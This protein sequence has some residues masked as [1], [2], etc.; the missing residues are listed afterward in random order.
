MQLS[1]V[2]VATL[3]ALLLHLSATSALEL[4]END[5]LVFPTGRLAS[6]WQMGGSAVQTENF[7][8]LTPAIQSRVGR[9]W[10]RQSLESDQ[11][12]FEL[13][14]RVNGAKSGADGFALWYTTQPLSEGP[15]FGSSPTWEGMVLFFDT[16]DNDWKRDNPFAGIMIN[17]GTKEINFSDDGRAHSP[18]GCMMRFRNPRGNSKA[19]VTYD[20]NTIELMVAVNDGDDY[21]PCA[22]LQDVKLPRD[23]YIGLSAATGGLVDNHDIHE[24]K[25]YAEPIQRRKNHQ[26]EKE[27]PKEKVGNDYYKNERPNLRTRELSEED[28]KVMEAEAKRRDEE[29]Q[30]V[31][32]QI[33]ET[34]R[35][36]EEKFVSIETD[37][38]LVLEQVIVVEEKL[39]GLIR[40]TI[41]DF[42]QHGHA[43]TDGGSFSFEDLEGLFEPLVTKT[44]IVGQSHALN[45]MATKND[46]SSTNNMISQAIS[47]LSNQRE[48][49]IASRS[50]GGMEPFVEAV[51]GLAEE[52]E[53]VNR[54]IKSLDTMM[55]KRNHA[56]ENLVRTQGQM[57]S[58]LNHYIQ[59]QMSW[60]F[61]EMLIYAAFFSSPL[62]ALAYLIWTRRRNGHH[63]SAQNVVGSIGAF[64]MEGGAGAKKAW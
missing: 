48:L 59:A 11:W 37:V 2:I 64:D 24:L 29:R 16:F 61:T 53:L 63:L 60:S 20:G 27:E 49:I 33:E 8:R 46:I 39:D 12:E 41:G 45:G 44:D 9:I 19:K 58:Q 56:L 5:S 51:E 55:T 3:L 31:L 34:A 22:T 54:K 57:A 14:F 23:G 13:T 43:A 6:H 30:M 4:R 26:E 62:V 28:R 15:V 47:E 1:V 18:A 7:L 52:L 35:R 36:D 38:A 25:V 40:K 50:G 21:Y 42:S 32:G 17:D 10:R